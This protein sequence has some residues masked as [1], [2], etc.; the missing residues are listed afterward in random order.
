MSI[1][2]S[3]KSVAAAGDVNGDGRDDLIIGA[4]GADPK[5]SNSGSSYV[6]FG[7]PLIGIDA[8]FKNGFKQ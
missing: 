1:R 4:Y 5:S 7:D 3:S 8:I 6:V 2:T